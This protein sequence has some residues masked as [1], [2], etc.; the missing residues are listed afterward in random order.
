MRFA[1]LAFIIG[2]ALG[3]GVRSIVISRPVVEISAAAA[4]D[5]NKQLSAEIKTLDPYSN[6]VLAFLCGHVYPQADIVVL[7]DL[8][9]DYQTRDTHISVIEVW[10]G[11]RKLTGQDFVIAD[12]PYQTGLSRSK[13]RALI[14]FSIAPPKIVASSFSYIN[15]E[16]LR[17]SP[18]LNL[19]FLRRAFTSDLDWRT[20]L[21]R[22]AP[23]ASEE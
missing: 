15:G 13:E 5:E 14:F 7:A 18:S 10:K 21:L 17:A 23:H 8:R 3:Y 4:A 20:R 16:S 11:P 9:F 1:I 12:G 22:L 19:S 6:R 2:L